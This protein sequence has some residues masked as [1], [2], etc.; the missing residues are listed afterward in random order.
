MT[1]LAGE[2]AA[3]N[4]WLFDAALP[5]W[6]Q[7]GA[8]R[9]RGGFH[10]AISLDGRPSPLPHRARVI[11]RQAFSYCEA[12]R[13]GWHG[14]WREAQR[15]ALDYL[16]NH[17]IAADTTIV[18]V[19]DLDGKVG[20]PT[21]DL[22]NQAFALLAFASG[23]RTFGEAAGWRGHAVAL[24]T[25]LEQSYAHPLGGFREDRDGRLPQRSNPHMHLLESALAWLAIDD[26]P[27]WRRMADAIAMLCLE[28]FIDPQTGALGEFFASDWSPAPGVEGLIREP[29]HHYEW[30]FLLHR[31]AQLTGR[32]APAAAPK[33]IAFA[34]A[35]G[36]DA[37]RGVAINAVLADGRMHDS[38]ARLWAQAERIRA[39]LT[40]GRCNADVAAA[41][42]GLRR[43]LATPA[44]GVWFDQL[45]AD[46]VFVME[47]AR[48]TS[49]YHIIGAVAELSH[50]LPA[51]VRVGSPVAKTRASAPRVIYLVTEDWYFISHRLPMAR[52]ARDSGFEVHVATRIDRHGAA[53]EA[54]GFQLHGVAWR[55][56]SLDPS[57]LFRVV[58]EVR[59]LYRDLGPDLAH[60]VALPAAVVGSLAAIGL[61]IACL[62][63]MTGLGTLFTDDTP[64]ARVARAV[65]WLAL[66]ALLNCSRAAVLVQNLDDRAVI[67]RLGLHRDRISLVPGSGVDVEAM[68][69][70]PEPSGP[71]TVAFVGRLLAS[72]GI[73][74]LVAAHEQLVQRGRDMQL[75]IAGLPDP[76]NPTSIPPQEIEAWTR[77]PNVKHLGFVDDIGALWAR[78]HIAVLP[79][80][81]EGLPLSLLEAAA[82]GRPLVATDVPG[83]RDIARAD[84][85]AL[86]VPVED[87][88]ALANAIDRLARDP[89]LR[90]KF[91]RAG[92]EL[93][94]Q[95]FSSKRIGRDV[96]ALYQRL[97][98]QTA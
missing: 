14:P 98:A 3:L 33:L 97:L 35:F 82:C 93:V 22:Y 79:S 9:V 40:H 64:K 20:D 31:W 2:A 41:I 45:G 29:G 71:I 26:D 50:M 16:R 88:E 17:F 74:T 15:H 69:P 92:R 12:G 91:G 94:E 75:L 48:A 5:L 67:E 36:L 28:K 37:R 8:D 81:R 73:R 25:R 19:V 56:G 39:Y 61:P 53:I 87:P 47:P 66:R 4:R 6:W 49:L 57:D 52:A 7:E 84:L 13:L 85:N 23:H 86:L 58:R 89:Q 27:A 38:V 90:R 80:H 70:T 34:D 62:N 10:E 32:N 18:S 59:K 55:R 95:N 83:C 43:F 21:F 68:K 78:A 54:E 60:H 30:A 24:R 65:L 51:A 42:K 76:A 72:K 63:A 77:Q 11:A 46:D 96:I 1:D 44:E